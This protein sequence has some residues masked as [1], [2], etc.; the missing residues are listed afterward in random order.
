[1]P[2]A[3]LEGMAIAPGEQVLCLESSSGEPPTPAHDAP[4]PFR[5]AA[6]RSLARLSARASCPSTTQILRSLVSGSDHR[7]QPGARRKYRYAGKDGQTGLSWR[8]PR[9]AVVA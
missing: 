9:A 4:Q 7:H 8:R 3:L 2:N 6:P 5:F 1:M